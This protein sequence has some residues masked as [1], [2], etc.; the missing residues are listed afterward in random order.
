MQK[1]NVHRELSKSELTS[2]FCSNFTPTC[3]EC[4]TSHPAPGIV[5][6]RGESTMAMCRECHKRMSQSEI[7]Q[8]APF[9]Y[10]RLANKLVAFKI[11]EVKFLL[12]SAAAGMLTT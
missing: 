10:N 8:D 7:C 12:V 5:S 11:P 3:S 9:M 1:L 2:V 4:S 6:V